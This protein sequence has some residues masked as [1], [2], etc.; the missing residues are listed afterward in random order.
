METFK[1][2]AEKRENLISPKKLRQ[3]DTL[4]AVI[5]GK[6]VENVMLQVNYQGRFEQYYRFGYRW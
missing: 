6:G 1:L 3:T 5:Y 2:K 4:P